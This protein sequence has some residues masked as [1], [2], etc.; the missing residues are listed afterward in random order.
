MYIPFVFFLTKFI[1]LDFKPQSIVLQIINPHIYKAKKL[2]MTMN[3]F[4]LHSRSFCIHG[5]LV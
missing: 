5:M 1:G 4:N 2:T 3:I